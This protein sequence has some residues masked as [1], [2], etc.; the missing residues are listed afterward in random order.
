MKGKTVAITGATSG[1]GRATALQLSRRGAYVLIVVRNE[2]KGDKVVKEIESE[3]GKGLAIISELSSMKDTREAAEKISN[4]V[5]RLDVLINNAGTW[6]PEYT[7]TSEG[8]EYTLAVNYLSPFLLTHHLIELMTRTASENGEARIINVSALLHRRHIN[9]DDLNFEQTAY[10]GWATY[11]QSKHML[12]SFTYYL[13]KKL[14]GTGISV[15]CIHP[16]LVKSA[17]MQSDFGFPVSVIFPLVGLLIGESPEQAADTPVWLASSNETKSI[18]GKYIHHRKIKK[19]WAPTTNEKDQE[20]L[21][22]VTR[23]ML[24]EWI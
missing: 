15:N 18:N 13:S 24:D 9:W 8:F 10:D 21:F 2:D 20:R 11:K 5:D 22:N 16:G 1:L 6:Q 12:T 3:G 7:E 19:S 4:A 17:L 23:G 14:K